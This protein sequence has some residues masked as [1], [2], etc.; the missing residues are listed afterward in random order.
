MSDEF[1]EIYQLTIRVAWKKTR[2]KS[3][4]NCYRGSENDPVVVVSRSSTPKEMNANP[5]LIGQIMKSMG[6]TG[7]SIQDF[8][9]TEV[10]DSMSLGKSFYYKK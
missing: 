9:V 3:Y 10:F 5:V 7:K 1:A 4:I 8:H 2:G 6:L